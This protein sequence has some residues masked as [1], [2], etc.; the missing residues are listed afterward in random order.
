M[1]GGP[2]GFDDGLIVL[3]PSENCLP[4]LEGAADIDF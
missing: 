2:A 1:I 4:L 3:G